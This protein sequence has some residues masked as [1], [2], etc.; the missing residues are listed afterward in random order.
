MMLPTRVI[1]ALHNQEGFK[2][3]TGGLGWSGRGSWPT[4]LREGYKCIGLHV[5]VLTRWLSQ[6]GSRKEALAGTGKGGG[7][8]EAGGNDV[9]LRLAERTCY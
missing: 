4:S 9:F 6:A 5:T 3:I 8:M 1:R 2:T 7:E